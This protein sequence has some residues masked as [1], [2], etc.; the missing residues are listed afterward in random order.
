MG[1]TQL[2]VI[3]DAFARP[4]RDLRISVTDRCNFRCPYCMPEEIFGDGYRFSERSEVLRFEEIERLVRLFVGL[5][6]RKL[7]ITGGEPLVRAQLPRFIERLS[8]YP[9]E[10]IALTTNGMLLGRYAAELAQAGLR[11]IT[12][13]LD[14]LRPDVFSQMSGGR[15]SLD[16]VLEG[17]AAAEAVGLPIKINCV[18]E[19]GVN[20]SSIRELAQHFRG[21]GHIVRYIEFMAVGTLNQWDQK[22]VVP[23]SEILEQL[24]KHGSL[25]S[26]SPR[27][28]GEVAK[29]YR[30]SDGSGEIGIIA[31]VTQP[32][33]GDC[34]RARIS[35]DGHLFTCLYAATGV[36]LREPLRSGESDET[37]LARIRSVWSDRKDRY[38]EERS[39]GIGGGERVE[40][41]R[42]GG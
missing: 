16:G 12:I 31:S 35:A 15:G 38:S 20:E 17:I 21:T 9:V 18:V 10:D 23:A 37:L 28:N 19:R 39:H 2:P 30:W 27:Y 29:R 13:S 25:E 11:R 40:M 4:L 7:R 24:R 6:V 14:S 42:I 32:F 34:T 1:V 26:V 3:G 5:G 8:A 41:Y 22:R 33:C 36:D